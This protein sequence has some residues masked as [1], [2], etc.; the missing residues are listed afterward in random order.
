MEREKY[1]NLFVD[2]SKENLLALNEYLLELEKGSGSL[3]LLNDIFRVAHTLKGMASTL[4]F[5]EITEL[6]HEMENLLDFLR[7]AQLPMTSEIIDVLFLCLDS[8]EI[9]VDNVLSSVPKIVDITNLMYR[10]KKL[11]KLGTGGEIV[12]EIK[13]LT[14]EREIFKIEYS[15]NEKKLIL[16]SLENGY[17]ASEIEVILMKDSMMK[18]IRVLL[19]MQAVEA[20]AKVIKTTP[21]RDDLS[22]EKFG[23]NF[24]VTIVHTL[25]LEQIKEAILSIAEVM[26]VYA[27]DIKQKFLSELSLNEQN[28]KEKVLPLYTKYNQT[29]KN[30]L[31]EAINQG[32]KCFE[33]YITLMPNTV[34]KFVRINMI[35]NCINNLDAQIIRSI[36]SSSEIAPENAPDNFALTIISNLDENTIKNSLLNISEINQIEIL[37]ILKSYLSES[38]QEKNIVEQK[39]DIPK[40]SDYEKLLVLDAN[41]SLKRVVLIGVHLMPGTV[42]KFARYVLVTKRLES[43][44]DIIKTIPSQD[45]MDRESFDDYFQIVFT[46]TTED[47]AIKETVSSVAEITN[48]VDLLPIILNDKKN[49]QISTPLSTKEGINIQNE[50]LEEL[51]PNQKINYE[52]PLEKVAKTIDIPVEIEAIKYSNVI[53]ESEMLE[54]NI[55]PE[56]FSE[57]KKQ[58]KLV[59]KKQTIRVDIE[60]LDE[61]INLVEELVIVRSR[62][63]KIGNLLESPELFQSV[64]NLSMITGN[65]QNNAMRLRMVPVEHIFNRFPRMIRDIAKSL[66][67]EIN[68]V[69]EGEETELDRTIIDEIGDPLVHLLRNSADHGIE[70]LQ[71]RIKAG[72]SKSGNIRLI[73]R[74]EGNNVLIIVEDDG[75]GVNI[76]KVKQKAIEKNIISKESAEFM[77]DHEAVQIIFLPGFSTVESATDLSG[78]GV[79]MD[80]VMSKVKSIG[81]SIY[82]YSETGIGTRF[83]IKL[84]LTLAIMEVLLVNIGNGVYAI[85]ITYIEEIK[86]LLPEEIKN[87]NQV[88]VTVVRDKTIPLI[89]MSE[90]LNTTPCD[91][92]KKHDDELEEETI[93][94]IIVRTEEGKKTNGLIVDNIIGQDDIVIKPL[95]KIAQDKLNYISGT[96]NLGDGNLALILNI[97]NLT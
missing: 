29:E 35:I 48:I 34:M 72:K 41:N 49:Y 20:K 46:T 93:P 17:N 90:K 60:R 21:S 59:S 86:E 91:K 13:H 51:I 79:G 95:G 97:T 2:E 37:E 66:N 78:R 74:H 39:M 6:T 1:I 38:T 36:P 75:R 24:I 7:N 81:G 54:T 11:I 25:P 56:I 33:I 30:V 57:E 70:S 62:L 45:E 42:M 32:F 44:G 23:R 5:K 94:V 9:L 88:K 87:I 92:L 61:L 67:K 84:P 77:S 58:K 65:I 85:P 22:H 53:E 96:A 89:D 52:K 80:A 19:I 12:E 10:L 76:E 27:E 71:Q 16:E 8:L 50:N 4:G 63:T 31:I 55:K 64:R 18:A 40:F 69:I 15:E 28:Q 14:E 68:F 3:Q 73:A 47:L 82:V 83:T 43:I 26:T